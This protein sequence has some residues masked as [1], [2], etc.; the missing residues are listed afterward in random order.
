MAIENQFGLK[1]F[2]GHFED[3]TGTSFEG[4]EGYPRTGGDRVRT[5]GKDALTR[6]LEN[7][8]F[9]KIQFFFPFPDYKIPDAVVS[10]AALT[11][12]KNLGSLVAN[13]AS[14]TYRRPYKNTLFDEELAWIELGRNRLIPVF[15]NSFLV[16]AS[17]EKAADRVRAPWDAVTFSTGRKP[18]FQLMTYFENLDGPDSAVRKV[19][20]HEPRAGARAKYYVDV[21]G[22]TKR[23]EEGVPVSIEIKRALRK[24]NNQLEK[25]TRILE[26]WGCFLER[27][28]DGNGMIDGKYID[29][30]PRNLIESSSG[31]LIFID[32]EWILA[33][34]VAIKT[35]MIRGIYR[36]IHSDA[37]LLYKLDYLGKKNKRGLL[38]YLCGALGEPCGWKDIAEFVQLECEMQNIF[39]GAR[40]GPHDAQDLWHAVVE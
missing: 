32:D 7:S 37:D 3:H 29:A 9:K 19:R 20:V 12:D 23:W 39:S 13:Y 11:C 27:H 30:I 21:E 10:E 26:K 18:E 40:G 14:R 33:E 31:E 2:A 6:M 8:G 28:S 38:R 17:K 34:S 25:L 35:L 5:F 4:I 1:Y 24:R 15:A 16:V 22:C 36:V